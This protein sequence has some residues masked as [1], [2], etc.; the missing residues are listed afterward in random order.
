M[1]PLCEL[2]LPLCSGISVGG[3][4]D[5]LVCNVVSGL[6]KYQTGRF[7]NL[8]PAVLTLWFQPSSVGLFPP[9]SSLAPLEGLPPFNLFGFLLHHEVCGRGESSEVL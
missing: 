4:E 6:V 2:D 5:R 9:D 8:P 1:D 3:L 7:F